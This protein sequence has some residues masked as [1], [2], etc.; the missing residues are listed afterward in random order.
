MKGKEKSSVILSCKFS[1][2]PKDVKW[3]KGELPLTASD[4]YNIKQDA[5]RA[6]ITIHK[7]TEEDSGEYCCQS[8]PAQTKGRL[9]VEGS[10]WHVNTQIGY[11]GINHMRSLK[12]FCFSFL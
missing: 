8:G 2:S 12:C 3:F 6:Q 4:K 11:T 7:L 9:T 5:T 10:V 1:A